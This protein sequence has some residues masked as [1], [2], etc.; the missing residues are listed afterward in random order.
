[1]SIVHTALHF[2]VAHIDD[3]T[4]P[5]KICYDTYKFIAYSYNI[6]QEFAVDIKVMLISHCVTVRKLH[7]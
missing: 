1:M 6:L 7:V 4:R 5:I 3:I 2:L